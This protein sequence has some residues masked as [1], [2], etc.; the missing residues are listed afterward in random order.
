MNEKNY[1][2]DTA[3]AKSIRHII[4]TYIFFIYLEFFYLYCFV[5]VTDIIH[6]FKEFLK[7]RI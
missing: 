5:L 3:L 4:S 1:K 7:Q 2:C 6:K